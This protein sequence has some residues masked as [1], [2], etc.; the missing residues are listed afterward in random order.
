[1]T[2]TSY[3]VIDRTGGMSRRELLKSTAAVAA[4]AAATARSRRRTSTR[5]IRSRCASSAPA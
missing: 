3:R 4:G 5:P 1:M 2:M